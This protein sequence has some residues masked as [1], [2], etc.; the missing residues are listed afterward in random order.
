MLI[1]FNAG[2]SCQINNGGCQ[3]KCTNTQRS[4]RCSCNN[5]YHLIDGYLC[6]G[7]SLKFTLIISPCNSLPFVTDNN[8][9]QIS[10]GGCAHTCNNTNGGYYCECHTGYILHQNQHD[11][12]RREQVHVSQCAK[13]TTNVPTGTKQ[14]VVI[15]LS[16]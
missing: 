15:F 2:L 12:V 13:V 9:C 16:A 10:N 8:E 3:Q 6:E 11:C 14:I 4:V 1:C 5:G 7:Q